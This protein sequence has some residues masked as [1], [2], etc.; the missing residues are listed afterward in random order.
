MYPRGAGTVQELLV[1]S[2]GCRRC[3]GSRAGTHGW[4]QQGGCGVGDS[5]DMAGLWCWKLQRGVLE[6]GGGTDRLLTAALYRSCLRANV[7]I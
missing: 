3:C 4:Q 7:F 6:L 2:G 1:G 5:E